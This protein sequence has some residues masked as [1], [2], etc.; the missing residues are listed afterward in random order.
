M[1]KL[2][3]INDLNLLSGDALDDL[4]S[5]QEERDSERM[6]RVIELRLDTVHDFKDHPFQVRDDEEMA[7]LIDS[8]R[9]NGVLMPALVRPDRQGGYEMVSGHRRKRASEL[10]GLET[11]PCIVRDLTDD[12]ATILMVDSNLQREKILPSE[13][14]FAYK[15]RLEAMERKA[16]RPSKKN[17]S[18]VATNFGKGRADKELAELVGESKDQIRRYIHLTDLIPEILQM[19]DDGKIKLR[20]AVEL[21]YL[22]PQEQQNLLECMQAQDCT[23]SHAQAIRMKKFSQES[24]LNGDVIEAI[25]SEQKPNQKEQFHMSYDKLHRYFPSGAT[26]KEITQTIIKALDLYRR[27]EKNRDDALTTLN[28]EVR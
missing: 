8:V 16:G 1:G 4:F 10:A 26:E 15:M 3:L 7:R 19:V 21:S 13:K 24:K 2:D 28:L 25:M 17:V 14:A 11:I 20:P 9:Q 18:P 23:P 12:E 5:S 6:E 22:K 27:R